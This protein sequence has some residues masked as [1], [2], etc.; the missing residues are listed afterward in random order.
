MAYDTTIEGWAA[1]ERIKPTKI[2]GMQAGIETEKGTSR[3]RSWKV[4]QGA[5]R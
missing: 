2:T 5:M 1:L 3:P 4:N